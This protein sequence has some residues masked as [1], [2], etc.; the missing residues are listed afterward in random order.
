V[1]EQLTFIA[2]F[3][4]G[5]TVLWTF[6]YRREMGRFAIFYLAIMALF[7]LVCAGEEISWGQRT[8]GFATPESMVEANEQGEFNL[9]NLG[10]RD[11]RPIAVVS[12]Y[13]KLFGI[14]LP[15]L[16]WRWTDG[17]MR[18]CAGSWARPTSRPAS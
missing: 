7:Y 16:L 1:L 2:Y 11:F 18:P 14:A 9:H 17:A 15:L 3:V 5:V 13:M 6:R 8:L 12:A 10:F 4:A